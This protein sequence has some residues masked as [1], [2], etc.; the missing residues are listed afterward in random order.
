[1]SAAC[2]PQL[3]TFIQQHSEKRQKEKQ[4]DNTDMTNA[5]KI[6]ELRECCGCSE[7]VAEIVS[8][9]V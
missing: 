4:L 9:P 2:C 7:P 5:D 3:F 6:E 8:E 1:M